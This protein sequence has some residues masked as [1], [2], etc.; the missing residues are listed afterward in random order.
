[1]KL[2]TTPRV[3]VNDPSLQRELRE[4]ADQVNRL[5]EV[6]LQQS[7]TLVLQRLLQRHGRRAIKWPIQRHPN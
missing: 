5:S 2:N 3:G 6:V 1:M 7:T 4:H